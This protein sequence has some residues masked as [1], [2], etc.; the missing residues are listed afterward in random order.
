MKLQEELANNLSPIQAPPI[1]AT[2]GG[3]DKGNTP[4]GAN[5]LGTPLPLI[6]IPTIKR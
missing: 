2:L 5:G 6:S 4:F 3:D 1:M